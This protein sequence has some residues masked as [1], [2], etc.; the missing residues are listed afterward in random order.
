V[1]KA[2]LVFLLAL[3]LALTSSTA[4]AETPDLLPEHQQWLETV[5]PIITKTERQIF[6][7][8]ATSEERAKFIQLFWKQRDPLPDTTENEFYK[9]YM[10][11]V[12]FADQNFG[13]GT[14]KKGSRTER[15]Y[16][17][18]LLGPPLERSLYTT[19]SELLPLELWFY[20]G[21][22][23][24]GLPPYFY[25][26][27]YQPMG[28]GEYR[29]Y[30]P[31]VEG[32]EKLVV[33]SLAGANP[34]RSSAYQVV[35]KINSEL[36]SATLSYLP[37]ERTVNLSS[38]SSDEIVASVRNLPEKEFSDAYA[39]NYLDYKDFVETEH[40]DTFTEST[41]LLKVFRVAGVDFLH[42]TLEPG[43]VNF[44]ERGGAY[45][46]AF[47]LVLRL[48][49]PS[50]RTVY[51]RTEE[52]PLRITLE[53]FERH[54]RQRFAF[55]DTLPVV[56]GDY[57]VLFLLKNKTGRDFSSQDARISVPPDS[58][59]PSLGPVL[60]YQA[61]EAADGRL[62]KAFALDG[63]QFLFDSR[64]EFPR[65]GTLGIFVQPLNLNRDGGG[66]GPLSVTVEIRAAEDESGAPAWTGRRGVDE[67]MPEG[68][69]GIDWEGIPLAGLKPG[70][71]QVEVGLS[72]AAGRTIA[73]RRDHFILL[74]QPGVPLPWAYSRQRPAFPNAE[75]LAVLGSQYFARGDYGRAEET[76]RKS[77]ALKDAGPTRLL[78]AKALYGSKSYKDSLALVTPV[79]ESTRDREAAK[80]IALDYAGLEDWSA[81]LVYL[82]DLLRQATEVGV[83]NLA[84]ECLI[85][86]G[87]SEEALP[88]LR[89]SL[90]LVPGQ[91]EAEKLLEQAR[92]AGH[93]SS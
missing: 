32:P 35:R 25:L 62:V 23:R 79:Y 3:G 47:E 28:M 22:E 7:N 85:R 36:A 57:R 13:Y 81:A 21:D 5:E 52:I 88:L 8:L 73:V 19:Q 53:Q 45:V 78:L 72:D 83:L 66:S 84:A 55:Q 34:S 89:K 26:I 92:K 15:G 82:Q 4:P 39:R 41:F 40:L 69:S 29:L 80:V 9:E 74:T 75:E 63:F 76:L 68:R 48:E 12:L 37:G 1:K 50:G 56:P 49:D 33:P 71:Y 70:Y 2:S 11:R 77:L 43:R 93:S 51:E 65:E 30:Y 64:N 31:G 27:F 17:Y 59:P 87:R 38:F 58:G 16:Y 10:S 24:Y 20:K 90:E 86:L 6:L 54:S 44:A 42:W 61:K 46:A 14:G 67:L 18:L 91:T 60:L